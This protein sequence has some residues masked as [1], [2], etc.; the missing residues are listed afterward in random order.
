MILMAI[1][2]LMAMLMMRKVF[3]MRRMVK[4]MA[5]VTRRMAM[6]AKFKPSASCAM[7]NLWCWCSLNWQLTNINLNPPHCEHTKKQ[8]AIQLIH[9]Q[10]HWKII[11]SFAIPK[12][13]SD[14][15]VSPRHELP[16]LFISELLL[17]FVYISDNYNYIH[18][19]C[20]YLTIK[21][22]TM[23]EHWTS[24]TILATFLRASLI[25]T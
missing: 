2:V 14:T 13:L 11:S 19:N 15:T 4:K 24:F 9:Q 22:V 18:D 20:S 3:M 25:L 16:S 12:K 6:K 10:D 23:G 7:C 5:M 8:L 1:I 17:Y 21:R